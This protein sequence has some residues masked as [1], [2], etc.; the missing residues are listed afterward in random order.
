MHGWKNAPTSPKYRSRLQN[1]SFLVFM[2]FLDGCNF[3]SGHV[4]ERGCLCL[5]GSSPSWRVHGVLCVSPRRE[6]QC[7][8]SHGSPP[9][10][11]N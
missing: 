1:T 6:Q 11:L 5:G 8:V 9:Y 7:T 2:D 3:P 10:K 4:Y